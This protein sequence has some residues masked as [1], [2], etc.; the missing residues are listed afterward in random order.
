MPV[1]KGSKS[2]NIENR[3]GNVDSQ[4]SGIQNNTPIVT[5]AEGGKVDDT[6]VVSVRMTKKLK[7][8]LKALFAAH[9]MNLSDG[10][11]KSMDCIR[12]MERLGDVVITDTQV[13]P[14]RR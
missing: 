14:G 1:A 4:L 9:G 7:N 13:I 8:D 6:T 5:A 3:V 12:Y 11:N 10:I 2:Q